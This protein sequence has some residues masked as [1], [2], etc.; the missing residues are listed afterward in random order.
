[1]SIPAHLHPWVGEAAW[2]PDGS[3]IASSDT[4][5]SVSVWD[6]TAAPVAVP[7]AAS[8]T[9]SA[10]LSPDGKRFAAR[11]DNGSVVVYDSATGKSLL[12]PLPCEPPAALFAWSPDGNALAVGSSDWSRFSGRVRLFSMT[13]GRELA[14]ADLDSLCGSVRWRRMANAWRPGDKRS[15]PGTPRWLTKYG[16]TFPSLASV[17][18]SRW[19]GARMADT[20][21]WEVVTVALRSTTWQAA[22]RSAFSEDMALLSAVSAGTLTCRVSLPAPGTMK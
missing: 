10:A 9:P 3:L 5:W 1:M 8:G 15:A 13:T 14:S 20:S 2:S 16:S 12:G 22:A 18:V 4:L 21:P 11:S 17:A 6:L 19:A 7:K